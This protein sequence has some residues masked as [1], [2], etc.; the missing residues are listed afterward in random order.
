LCIGQVRERP[1]PPS[2]FWRR[3]LRSGHPNPVYGRL[4][5][6]SRFPMSRLA[7]LKTRDSA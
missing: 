3:E 7:R 5:N 6:L 2:F 4:P 1:F